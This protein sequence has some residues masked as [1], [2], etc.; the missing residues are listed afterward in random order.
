M[1]N[2]APVLICTLN[3]YVHFKRCVD[4]LAAC[5][6]ARKTDLFIS[7]DYPLKKTHWTGYE[8]IKAFL[9]TIKG[10][11][12][13][14]IV[15]REKN[16]GVYDNWTEMQNYILER[17]DRMIISEDD[18]VFAPSFLD[19]VNKGLEVYKD[20]D[21]IFSV[22][23]YNSPFPM[24]D[25]YKFDAYLRT[26]FT[27]WGVGIWKDKWNKIDWSLTSYN[28]MLAKK[29]N[30]RTI[31]KYYLRYLPQ[32]LRIK[33]TGVITGDGL[34]FLYLVDKQMYSLFPTKTRVRNTGH[35]GSGVNSGNPKK[36][37]NI[38]MNQK[39]YE[40]SEEPC[41]PADIALDTRLDQYVLK[42]IQPTLNQRIFYYLPSE[43]QDFL[44]NI[45][46][47]K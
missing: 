4:S 5:T 46:K 44:R 13:V 9:P 14:K 10:F 32:L 27:G 33:D 28:K 15:I 2:F 47:R 6:N 16:Y 3:R 1:N 7:L 24:P 34:I 11:K 45:I 41:F 22:S 26:G 19:F 38:Y 31:K 23:G 25:W 40:G 29:Q 20:R 12:S 36:G 42:Q 30:F 35:D 43:L 37:Y 21:D 39:V 8:I 18:N 17:Y